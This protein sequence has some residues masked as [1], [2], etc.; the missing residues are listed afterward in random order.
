MFPRLLLPA[1]KASL[2]SPSPPLSADTHI[3]DVLQENEALRQR[4]ELLELRRGEEKE[5]LEE[6]V[7]Q[8][9]EELLR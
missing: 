8:A 3:S 7:A 4:L 6:D 2:C 9:R 5:A 1:N